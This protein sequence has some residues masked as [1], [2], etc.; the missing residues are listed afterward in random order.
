MGDFIIPPAPESWF[1]RI[2]RRFT[3][4][5]AIWAVIIAGTFS[6][7][8]IF[9]GS[10]LEAPKLKV[11]IEALKGDIEKKATAIQE[12]D[13]KIQSL[14]T[15]LVPFRTLTIEKF[16]NAEQ[17]QLQKYAEYITGLQSNYLAQMEQLDE[18]RRE[19]DEAKKKYGEPELTYL[20]GQKCEP[21]KGYLAALIAYETSNTIPIKDGFQ[22]NAEIVKGDAR[23]VELRGS[24]AWG[25]NGRDS[26]APD[27]KSATANIS[28]LS[29]G[30]PILRIEV[31]NPC[32]VQIKCKQLR[33]PTTIIIE[34]TYNS[35]PPVPGQ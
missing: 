8:G 23:I 7:L 17:E 3:L 28:P 15:E 12:K 25:T 19:S 27:G 5:T 22:F 2:K 13:I 32:V 29:G 31:S 35:P 16:G 4:P 20:D 34:G 11:K 21:E 26:I 10:Q 9:L 6:L 33:E 30:R 18:L 24:G 1:D 14:E